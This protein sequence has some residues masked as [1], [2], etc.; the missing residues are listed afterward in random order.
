MTHDQ[1]LGHLGKALDG[2]VALGQATQQRQ[3]P[4]TIQPA[5]HLAIA[6]TDTENAI[7][8]VSGAKGLEIA[9]EHA[10][11]LTGR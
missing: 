2:I 5:R 7:A 1:I 11:T 8:R 9:H 4:A 10:T 3:G 6:M